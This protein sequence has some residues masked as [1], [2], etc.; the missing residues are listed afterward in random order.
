[1]EYVTLPPEIKIEKQIEY[2]TL[3]PEIKI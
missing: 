3:P 2:I 1:V